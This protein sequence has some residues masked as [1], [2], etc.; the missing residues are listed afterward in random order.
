M[1]KTI[2]SDQKCSAHGQGKACFT[3]I[4]LLVVIAIIA[5][6]AGMLLPALNK[7]RAKARGI[8]CTSNK[9]ESMLAQQLYAADNN[10]MYI[11]HSGGRSW[12]EA[13]TGARKGNPVR[14]YTAYTNWGVVICPALNQPKTYDVNFTMKTSSGDAKG[15]AYT[16]SAGVT[17]AYDWSIKDECGSSNKT[18][19]WNQGHN[20]DVAYIVNKMKNASGLIFIGDSSATDGKVPWTYFNTSATTDGVKLMTAHEDQIALAYADG[21]AALVKGR[22]LTTARNSGEKPVKS[23]ADASHNM[24][25]N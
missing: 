13:L 22:G 18:D 2:Y 12:A 19:N 5:I 17:A 3:L 8:S 23:Y 6:L 25:L 15:V 16:G 24:I 9:K 4:E 20:G 14:E 11:A 10:D 1:K 21:H 7:A